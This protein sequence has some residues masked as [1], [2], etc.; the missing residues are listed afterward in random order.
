MVVL[1]C[2]CATVG[3]G[4]GAGWIEEGKATWYGREHHGRLTA[5]GERFDMNAFTAA[6]K[7]LRMG[8]RVEVE[9]LRNGRRV[10]VRINDR[11]PYGAGRIIDV[12]LAAARALDMV[13]AG[14]VPARI[15]VVNPE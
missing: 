13:N 9:N 3:T 15:R 7:A 12:S 6:H 5:S 14:V 10:V 2:G 4:S 1:A 11:G 8:T